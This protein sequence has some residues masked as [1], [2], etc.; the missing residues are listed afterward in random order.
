M[1]TPNQVPGENLSLYL[2]VVSGY[3]SESQDIRT[4][5]L[6]GITIVHELAHAVHCIMARNT[7]GGAAMKTVF[8]KLTGESAST[9]PM[10]RLEPFFNKED[11]VSEAL[12]LGGLGPELGWSLEKYLFSLTFQAQ[13]TS[14]IG[15]S[16]LHHRRSLTIQVV[17]EEKPLPCFRTHIN[18]ISI[19]FKERNWER[20]HQKNG[21]DYTEQFLARQAWNCDIGVKNEFDFQKTGVLIHRRTDDIFSI[22]A[23]GW[24]RVLLRLRVASNK[25]V[26]GLQAL[27]QDS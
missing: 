22:H 8:E 24:K 4:S 9:P 3:R 12:S 25:C 1:V 21:L 5:F 10:C 6:L 17:K 2:H 26:C 15:A 19:F 14:K 27:L 7:S 16:R 13:K 23:R 18:D 20:L 11:V